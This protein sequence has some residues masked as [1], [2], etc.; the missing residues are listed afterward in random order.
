MSEIETLAKGLSSRQKRGLSKHLTGSVI[1]PDGDLDELQSI[2]V[3]G[4][5]GWIDSLTPLGL[6]VRDYLKGLS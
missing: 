4:D 2:G 5:D 6:Q 1:L 3:T